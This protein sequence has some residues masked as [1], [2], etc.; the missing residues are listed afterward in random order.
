VLVFLE[1]HHQKVGSF[2]VPAFALFRLNV[3]T[4][5]LGVQTS[6]LLAWAKRQP[7]TRTIQLDLL[8][9]RSHIR[10][11]PPPL[12]HRPAT[13]CAANLHPHHF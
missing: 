6:Q 5:V 8:P 4:V 13:N 11:L 2:D 1:S 10:T 7:V 9:L 12:N 3:S